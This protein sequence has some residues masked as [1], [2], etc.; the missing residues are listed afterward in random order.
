MQ[1]RSNG[2]DSSQVGKGPKTSWINKRETHR[3]FRSMRVVNN[4]KRLLRQNGYYATSRSICDGL[5]FLFNSCIAPRGP[6]MKIA[7]G[8]ISEPIKTTRPLVAE[9][10]A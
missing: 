10:Q 9:P 6:A 8:V 1:C 3:T 5:T 2:K 4:H 7:V